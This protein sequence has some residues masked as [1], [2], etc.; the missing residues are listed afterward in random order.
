MHLPL[1][2]MLGELTAAIVGEALTIEPGIG[3]AVDYARLIEAE[4]P[5]ATML[6]V[7]GL[8]NAS[9]SARRASS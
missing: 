8:G 2:F 4:S 3:L 5:P 7:V 1:V 9:Y 6:A